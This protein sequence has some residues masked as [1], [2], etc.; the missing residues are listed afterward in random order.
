[1][2]LIGHYLRNSAMFT[3]AQSFHHLVQ[4]EKA[5]DHVLITH[6]VYSFCRHP[7]YLGWFM[8]A[9]GT[10]LVLG[11]PISFAAF[12][13]VSWSFF[14]DRIPGEEY[15]LVKFFGDEY[16]NYCKRTPVLIPF[17]EKRSLI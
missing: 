8:W 6:G 10:Q 3:A 13:Y 17:L 16:V 12:L 7:S 2:V 11:N 5:S 15:N 14:L 1:M 9:N 4:D